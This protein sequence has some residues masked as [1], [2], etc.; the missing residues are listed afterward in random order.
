MHARN[1][2]TF[3]LNFPASLAFPDPNGTLY[4]NNTHFAYV[5]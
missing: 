3:K 2:D 5:A 4:K 1:S